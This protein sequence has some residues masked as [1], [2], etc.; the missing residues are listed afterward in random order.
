MKRLF[1]ISNLMLVVLVLCLVGC[2]SSRRAR[3]SAGRPG[4][5][6]AG[7]LGGMTEIRL[8]PAPAPA[9]IVPVSDIDQLIKAAQATPAGP[10]LQA[11]LASLLPS[12]S[13]E[14]VPTC[15][16]RTVGEPDRWG[17]A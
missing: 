8:K 12:T 14:Q 10:A 13:E 5:A 9:G 17:P 1:T 15:Y 6:Q 7:E 11:R 3:R 2:K 4:M 16:D